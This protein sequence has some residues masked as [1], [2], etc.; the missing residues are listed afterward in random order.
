MTD[1][2]S[3]PFEHP[4]NITVG[5]ARVIYGPMHCAWRNSN[6]WHLPGCKFTESREDAYACAVEMNRLMGGVE[7]SA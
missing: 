7:V 2:I 3:K 4:Q 1:P 6:G 5:L